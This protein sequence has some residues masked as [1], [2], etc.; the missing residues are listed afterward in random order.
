MYSCDSESVFKEELP[1]CTQESCKESSSSFQQQE[2]KEG[3]GDV[4]EEGRGVKGLVKPGV[5]FMSYT[6][7]NM[8]FL[9]FRI[10][11]FTPSLSSLHL[12]L[13]M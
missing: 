4:V 11:L 3:G 10:P 7:V 1:R 9:S 13:T 8:H 12:S 6:V 2:E 5:L